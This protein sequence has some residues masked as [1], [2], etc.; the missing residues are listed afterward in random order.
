MKEKELRDAD[1]VL[2]EDAGETVGDFSVDG[3]KKKIIR[4]NFNYYRRRC[5]CSCIITQKRQR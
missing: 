4:I 2:V 5:C 3:K 1:E